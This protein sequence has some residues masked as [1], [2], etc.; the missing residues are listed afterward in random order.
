MRLEALRGDPAVG[1]PGKTDAEDVIGQGAAVG[2]SGLLGAVVATGCRAARSGLP[3][4]PRRAGSRCLL[5]A[6]TTAAS[7]SPL[8]PG[9]R[10][11]RR[12]PGTGVLAGQLRRPRPVSL[13][14]RV[15]QVSD[16]VA[17]VLFLDSWPDITGGVLHIDGATKSPDRPP[18]RP[19][20]LDRSCRS[21]P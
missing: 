4:W 6:W 1:Q 3:P 15:G 12:H 13:L 21:S 7:S 14:G 18:P 16:V 11:A 5:G 10:L 8:L 2:V 9:Q 19:P 20:R 17:G